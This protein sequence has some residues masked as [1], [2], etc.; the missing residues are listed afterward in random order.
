M[1]RARTLNMRMV[2]FAQG[3][4]AGLPLRVRLQH[5]LA[6]MLGAIFA[7]VLA[8]S[9]R[10]AL[11]WI[12]SF[13]NDYITMAGFVFG[14][15]VAT[16]GMRF[17]QMLPTA[18]G[19]SCAVMVI[20]A[21]PCAKV[22]V[23]GCAAWHGSQSHAEFS[24]YLKLQ[25][26]KVEAWGDPVPHHTD[27]EERKALL[28]ANSP[29]FRLGSSVG[30]GAAGMLEARGVL[31][32]ALLTVIVGLSVAC[33]LFRHWHAENQAAE[34]AAEGQQET[35]D[36]PWMEGL[37]EWPAADL[38]GALSRKSAARARRLGGVAT[39]HVGAGARE[40]HEHPKAN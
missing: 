7:G 24:R 9:M 29:F 27:A 32:L 26:S 30:L 34:R 12:G 10:A 15:P 4:A 23:L 6:T 37:D 18:V 20:G 36:E 2:L 25:R 38:S 17:E 8:C 14:L 21:T 13:D 31:M 40:S 35:A 22:L 16:P 1:P 11:E 19:L 28:E 5:I 39:C 33:V 3:E